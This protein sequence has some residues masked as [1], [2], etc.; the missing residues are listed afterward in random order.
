LRYAIKGKPE[1]FTGKP[2]SAS[3]IYQTNS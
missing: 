2:Q 1:L 3:G